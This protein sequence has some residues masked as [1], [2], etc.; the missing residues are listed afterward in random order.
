MTGEPVQTKLVQDRAGL[1]SL[2][3]EAHRSGLV[4]KQLEHELEWISNARHEAGASVAA[5]TVRRG[6]SLAAYVPLRRRTIPLALRIG[7]VSMVRIPFR[8]VELFGAGIVGDGALS[9]DALLAINRSLSG[10]D[11]ITFE[12]VPTGSPMGTVIAGDAVAPLVRFERHRCVHH[13]I[14]L[15]ASFD[16]YWSKLPS[17]TRNN[18]KRREKQIASAA[19][20]VTM[21]RLTEPHDVVR[22]LEAIGSIA[23]GTFH[24][25]LLHRNLTPSNAPLVHNWRLAAERGW[26]RGYLLLSG[27][28]PIAYE[29]GFLSQRTL[30]GELTGYD[31]AAAAYGPG[32]MLLVRVIRDLIERRE[33]DQFDF[34]TGS[35]DYKRMLGTAAYEEASVMLVSPTLSAQTIAHAERLSS[36]FSQAC[37]RCLDTLGLKARVKTAV[38]AAFGCS[39]APLRE[40]QAAPVPRFLVP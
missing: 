14:D 21:R 34:G 40:P 17:K 26:L 28:R 15:P 39:I 3:R 32:V 27:D 36:Q 18:L 25:R 22:L 35:A 30:F 1:Q 13:L 11:A 8:V 6:S 31:A 29:V 37:G 38:R 12:G 19:K 2:G 20:D 24:E 4:P 7:E 16:D 10:F 9:R 23:K 33:A 5:L